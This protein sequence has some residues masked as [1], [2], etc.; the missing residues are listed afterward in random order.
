MSEAEQQSGIDEQH[1]AQRRAW[2][3]LTHLQRL[4]WLEQAKCFAARALEA[5]RARAERD[6]RQR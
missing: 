5:A 2:L 6:D 1:R 3:R 4:E